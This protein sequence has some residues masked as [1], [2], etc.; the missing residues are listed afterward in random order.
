MLFVYIVLNYIFNN[1]HALTILHILNSSNSLEVGL[2][3][4]NLGVIFP[5]NKIAGS[6]YIRIL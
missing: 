1:M 6:F 3:E 5:K 4:A 2:C